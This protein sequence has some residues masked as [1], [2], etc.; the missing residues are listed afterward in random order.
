[1]ANLR[2]YQFGQPRLNGDPLSVII[3]SGPYT[4][5]SSLDF[6]PFDALCEEV[7]K[8]RPDV[9]ILVSAGSTYKR[10]HSLKMVPAWALHRF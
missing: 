3:A 10:S 8:T 1:V 9:V 5:D 2:E 7:K 6:A 4:T